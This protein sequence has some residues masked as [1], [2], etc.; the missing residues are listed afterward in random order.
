MARVMRV[1]QLIQSRG[2]WT[3]ASIAAELECSDRTVYRDL[4][5]LELAGVPYFLEKPG[6]F[7]RVRMDYRF[8]VL[9]LTDDD[10]V[11]QATATN[12]SNAAGLKIN[13]GASPTTERIAATNDQAAAV[14]NDARRLIQVLDLKI[15][16]HSQHQQMIRVVQHALLESKQ[17]TGIYCSPHETGESRLLLHPYRLCLI[18]SAWYL[19][20]R[21]SDSKEPRTYRIARFRSLRML[22]EM[23]EQD[24]SFNVEAYLGNAWAVFRGDE[25][26]HI[27]LE[28]DREAAPVV[29]ETVWHHTQQL[30]RHPDGTASLE[31]DVDGLEEIT[32]WIIGWAGHVKILAPEKLRLLVIDKH[33]EAIDINGK[34]P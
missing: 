23:S 14:L 13:A 4:D 22:Q 8:P 5:V 3:V 21:P 10:L 19:I 20:A 31:F 6:N 18:K 17:V 24:N 12:V 9:N 29:T 32:R 1:L 33:R 15:V 7:I 16:D 26:Y 34:E 27:A 28:F 25:R 11:G 30:Q 2:R